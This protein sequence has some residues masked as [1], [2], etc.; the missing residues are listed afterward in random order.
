MKNIIFG[1]SRRDFLKT[2]VISASSYLLQACL[3]QSPTQNAFSKTV[4]PSGVDTKQIITSEISPSPSQSPPKTTG[5]SPSP[6]E[7]PQLEPIFP[8]MVLVKPGTFQMGSEG[9]HKFEQPVHTVTLTKP[10]FI[11]IYAVTYD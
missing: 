3:S 7:V 8:Q 1:S 10:F 4:E 11:G 9:G 5:L 2:A 6:T